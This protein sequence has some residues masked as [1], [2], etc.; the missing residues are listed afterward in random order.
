MK[1][2]VILA[3]LLQ[4]APAPPREIID[5]IVATVEDHIITLSDIRAERRMREVL[6]EPVPQNERE[7]LDELIDQHLIHTQLEDFPDVDPSETD[8]NSRLATIKDRKGLSDA[9][10]RSALIE[11]IRI[12]RFVQERFG[13]FARATP[14]E[15]TTYY[16]EVFLPAAQRRGLSP[17]P[18]ADEVAEEIRR[19]IVQEKTAKQIDLWLQQARKTRKVEIFL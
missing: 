4:S 6:G 12:E 19:N 18:P 17:I 11:H 5:R 8:V 14:E 15:I 9:T 13:Q 10:I 7:V 3:L 2:I 1:T 16:N